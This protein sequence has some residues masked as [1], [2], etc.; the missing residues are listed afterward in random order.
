LEK[1][2]PN[3]PRLAKSKKINQLLKKVYELEV[4]KKQIKKKNVELVDRNVELYDINQGVMDKHDKTQYGNKLLMKENTNLYRQLRI[5]RLKMK[6]TWT[7]TPK[8]SRLE[9]IAELAT[10]LEKET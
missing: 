2:S 5:L 4:S 1:A 6:E 10:S 8:H 7:P 3:R 9:T